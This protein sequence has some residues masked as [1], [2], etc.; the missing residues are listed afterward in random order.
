MEED[1]IHEG[2]CA[3]ARAHPECMCICVGGAL[4]ARL[5][6]SVVTGDAAPSAFQGIQ[7]EQGCDPATLTTHAG[8][9]AFVR[10]C[11]I[12]QLSLSSSEQLQAYVL[13]EQML[14]ASS[15]RLD[16]HSLRPMLIAAGW[17]AT[18]L[19]TDGQERSMEVL[20]E[21]LHL[22]EAL[23]VE[24]LRL[25]ECV[26]RPRPRPAPLALDSPV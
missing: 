26:H 15:C 21:P 7:L 11:L 10:T 13:I 5:F 20:G 24:C 2:V 14:H 4:S 6:A 12:D 22:L 16:V 9:S 8:V 3:V 25:L 1:S 23:E 17:L 19:S 18:K